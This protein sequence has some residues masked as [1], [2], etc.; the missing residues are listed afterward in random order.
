L[1]QHTASFLLFQNPVPVSKIAII[2]NNLCFNHVW[3]KQKF[4]NW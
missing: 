4:R 3:S 1:N 2:C